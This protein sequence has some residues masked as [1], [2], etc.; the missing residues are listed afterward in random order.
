MSH[1]TDP[2]LSQPHHPFASAPV[3]LLTLA[4]GAVDAISFLALG[5]VFTSVMTANL[6]LLGLSVGS[7]E[8]PL[9]GHSLLA[10]A[11]YVCGVLLGSRITVRRTGKRWTGARCALLVETVLLCGATLAWALWGGAPHS[12]GR[13][14]L[15]TVMSAAMGVQGGAVRAA[16]APGLST[17]YLTGALTGA[18][19]S[20]MTTGRLR[21]DNAALVVVLM[22]GAALGG[23]MLT[24]ARPAAAGLPAAL[25]AAALVLS[26]VV[27]PA[28]RT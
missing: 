7:W 19:T 8:L 20:L 4:T 10:I 16:G 12:G 11:G 14:A 23:L 9:A 6:A 5:G 15:L 26:F 28:R 25:V 21:W 22:A 2:W 13:L 3:L 24:Q 1:D 17:T 18:L 27:S